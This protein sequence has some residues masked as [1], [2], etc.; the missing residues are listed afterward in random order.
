M[1]KFKIVPFFAKNF[2]KQKEEKIIIVILSLYKSICR[3]IVFKYNIII[4]YNV[5]RPFKSDI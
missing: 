2:R 3:H 1:S 5:L 4:W